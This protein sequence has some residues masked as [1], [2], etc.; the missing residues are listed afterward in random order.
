MSTKKFLGIDARMMKPTKKHEPALWECML[1]TVYA[2]NAE[3]S[4]K[5]FDYD[6][7]AAVEWAGIDETSDPRWFKNT[8]RIN[9]S[10]NNGPN[11][12][13]G[14]KVLWAKRS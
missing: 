7:D 3:G 12:S 4:S 6:H 2:M 14:R 8:E 13:V 5:Y 9:W 1:G 10:T 11:P